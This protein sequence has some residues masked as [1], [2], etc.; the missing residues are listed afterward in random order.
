MNIQE[1][2]N[3]F[4]KFVKGKDT[5]FNFKCAL[6]RNLIKLPVRGNKCMHLECY[7]YNSIKDRLK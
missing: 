2:S 6:T 7:D 1:R 3:N 4:K 5:I